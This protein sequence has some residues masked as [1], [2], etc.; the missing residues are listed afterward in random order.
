MKKRHFSDIFFYI[1]S[2]IT[3]LSLGFGVICLKKN[4]E[5]EHY[6]NAFRNLMSQSVTPKIITNSLDEDIEIVCITLISIDTVGRLS[7]NKESGN[8][9]LLP[10]RSEKDISSL[11]FSKDD[12]KSIGYIIHFRESNPDN[13]DGKYDPAQNDLTMIHTYDSLRKETGIKIVKD[14]QTVLIQENPNSKFELKPPSK[15]E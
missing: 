10:R 9:F 3:V 8:S 2:A 5:I 1:L 12:L 14:D 6:A 4:E 7:F 13:P 11:V 15:K